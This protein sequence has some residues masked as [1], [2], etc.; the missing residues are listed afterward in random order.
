MDKQ[1]FSHVSSGT[2][3]LPERVADQITQLIAA[4]ELKSGDRLPN[5]FELG[6]QLGVGR[7]TIREAVKLLVARNVL[8][9]Q[10]GKGT[11][12]ARH[13]G[14]MEDPFGFAFYQDK[15]K[16]AYD[17]LE[18]R[19]HLE[20]WAASLAAERATDTDIS[21]IQKEAG[22]VESLIREGAPHLEADTRFHTSIARSTQNQVILKVLPV[23]SYSEDL[24]GT[25]TDATVQAE[26]ISGHKAILNAICCHNASAAR[27][28]MEAHLDLNRRM[29]EAVARRS[30]E[31]MI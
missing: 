4:R 16:L 13:P 6:S 29:I 26:T 18:V 12:I 8:T 11:F 22:A 19:L 3:P 23:I 27:A 21:I 7:G 10:R 15:L 31:T 9:I 24:F 2:R 14:E 20:P 1:N 5:E 30:K 28:A 17:L 25:T